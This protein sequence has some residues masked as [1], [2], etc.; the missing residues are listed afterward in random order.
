MNILMINKFLHQHGGSETYIIKLGAYLK[1]QGH[2][3][4][5]FGMS[6]PDRC[7]G[8]DAGAYTSF[9]DFHEA[10]KFDR[11]KYSLKTIYSIE[12]RKKIRLVLDS[13]KPDVCHLNNI[14]FQLTPSIIL[15]IKKW[16]KET[17][18][19]CRIVSTAHDYQWIC[20]NHM[21][22]NPC[23][24]ENCEKCVGGKFINCAK[25]KCIHKSFLKS[26][27]GTIEGYFW[28]YK[29]VYENVD[30]IICCSEFLKKKL[31]ADPE[32]R[33]KTTAIHNFVD[34]VEWK[35]AEKKDYV[36]YFGRFAPEK[37]IDTLIDACKRL[38]HIQFV[39]AGKGPL[40]YK[41]KDVP[42][43]RNAGFVNE[44]E[45]E[46]LIREARFSIYPSQWYENCP[47]SVIES[48]MY[49][50]PV[51]GADIGG[52]PELIE[53]EK[54][55]VLFEAGNTEDLI[56]KILYLWNNKELTEKLSNNCKNISF[57]T[58]EQYY[59]KIIKIYTNGGD[60]A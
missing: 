21:L 15:E 2:N 59:E 31:D 33:D 37:G 35:N 27:I 17:G 9:M 43:V 47:F 10:S 55:G 56:E 6:H 23:T 38:P 54:T 14:N 25:N 60:Y 40:E 22:N 30:S 36:L 8:N 42:N 49:S 28:K 32:F 46:V 51:I 4:Q 41:L 48:Q 16:S 24:K 26:V 12:A 20:P 5:Y 52:I 39:F 45:L 29:K 11:I 18:K 50:T 13:F 34:K 19:S 3:V 7:V 44:K 57:D 1:E 58:V 53:A